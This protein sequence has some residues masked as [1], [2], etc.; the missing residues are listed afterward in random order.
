[1]CI[2]Y[3]SEITS[4]NSSLNVYVCGR[5]KD[6]GS[7]KNRKAVPVNTSVTKDPHVLIAQGSFGTHS[8]TCSNC[9]SDSEMSSKKQRV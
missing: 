1:M 5:R 3:F 2:S 6:G 8:S 7:G 9:I 4:T